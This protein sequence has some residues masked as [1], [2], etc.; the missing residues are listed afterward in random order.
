ME[1]RENVFGFWKAWF[2]L[3]VFR[4][5]DSILFFNPGSTM[6]WASPDG[7][8]CLYIDFVHLDTIPVLAIYHLYLYVIS[9]SYKWIVPLRMDMAP[10]WWTALALDAYDVSPQLAAIFFVC[11]CVFCCYKGGVISE[12]VTHI[13]LGCL[14]SCQGENRQDAGH[15]M[16]FVA[17]WPISQNYWRNSAF[18]HS[19]KGQ[20]RHCLN[21]HHFDF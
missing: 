6:S 20:V 21:L 16:F 9:L 8:L 12:A 13:N 3:I 10:V 11:I 1:K 4:G 15:I 5:W 19:L 17:Q 7:Q 14:I 18:T 2:K